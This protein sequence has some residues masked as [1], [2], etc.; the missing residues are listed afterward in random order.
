MSTSTILSN[1]IKFDPTFKW[2]QAELLQFTTRL[3]HILATLQ[4]VNAAHRN[5]KPANLVFGSTKSKSEGIDFD[6]LLI[7]NFEMATCFQSD[8]HYSEHLCQQE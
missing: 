7:C 6:N 5:I 8:S 1:V 2:T 3:I 4:K